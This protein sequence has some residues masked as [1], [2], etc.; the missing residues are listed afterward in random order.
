MAATDET[1]PIFPALA[2]VYDSLSP[3]SYAL[4]RFATGA[5]LVP[6][7]VQKILNVP[8]AKFAQNIAAKG[9][10]FPEA[11]SY[12]TYFTESAA[13]ACLAIGLFTRIA[14]A[15]VGIEMLVI[16]FVFQ[17]QFGYFWT[18]RG[19]EFALL[20]VLLCIAIFFKGGGRYSVDRL[21][22]REF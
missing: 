6:H 14:A 19:Y 3:L 4:M 5:I 12:L 13:A 9:L 16:V 8:V 15:M 7:G 18:N 2:G 11:L 22:G 10:P 21:I 17:W 20:W 1:K